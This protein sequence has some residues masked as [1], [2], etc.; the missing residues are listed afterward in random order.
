L[1]GAVA[2]LLLISTVNAASLMT[3]FTRRRQHE[4]ALRRA[5]GATVAR[6]LRQQLVLSAALGTTATSV[7][8]LVA[9]A[10]TRG[11]I[12]MM[13]ADVPRIAEAHVNGTVLVFTLVVAGV[14]TMVIGLFSASAGIFAGS[15]S[16]D[17]ATARITARLRGAGLVSAELAIG[18]VLSVLAALMIRSFVNLGSVDLGFQPQ[19]VA[20]G[21]VSLPS[22]K[23][24]TEVQWRQFFDALKSRARAIPGV[25]SVSVATPSPYACCAPS[26]TV[27]DASR[28]DDRRASSPV[29]D[30][31]FVDD[32]Y[33]P[34][35]RVRLI[36]GRVFPADEPS[37][38]PARVIVSQ[39]LAR[40]VWG[41][42]DPIGRRL[43]ISL[44]G[45][46]IAEVIGVVADVH[47]ADAR[48]PA[49]PAAYLSANRFPS[50]ERDVIVRGAVDPTAIIP[51]LRDVLHSLDA[52]IPL[53]RATTLET[54]VRETL[55]E[56]RLITTL[57]SAFALLALLL[58]TVGVHGVLS[59]DV[60]RR[61]KEIGIRLAL[62][63]RRRSVYAFVL[64]Q[65]VP[66]VIRGLLIGLVAALLISRAMSALVFG[67]GTSDP[68][69]FAIVIG[70]LTIV[71]IAA[72]WLPA[73]FASRVSPLEAIRAE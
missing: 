24:K 44:Y 34:T 63:A 18:L 11:L 16:L 25:T 60:T 70:V 64:G 36:A 66:A 31:R 20:V 55:A 32:A 54:T 27:V 45:T 68:L 14:T 72:T 7:G 33:F 51:A 13:P 35:L 69:S 8:L 56:D 1:F 37:D 39:S 9:L 57:L 5:I 30:F 15:S 28:A 73:F 17:V 29:T 49:R 2:L 67:I 3:S 12:A 38:G 42:T 26:T 21:R 4:L 46:T 23:Y 19:G 40:A 43:S 58:A 41:S 10:T 6:L 61:R 48:T 52:S 65:A 47:R 62:G 71:A 22:A 59:A 53:Y 50:F